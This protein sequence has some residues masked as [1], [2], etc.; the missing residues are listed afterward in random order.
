MFD[1]YRILPVSMEGL[2]RGG[3]RRGRAGSGAGSAS[4]SQSH[5]VGEKSAG[6]AFCSEAFQLYWPSTENYGSDFRAKMEAIASDN[7][8]FLDDF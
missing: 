1:C 4:V 5:L 6:W 2:L 8:C 7:G 3:K